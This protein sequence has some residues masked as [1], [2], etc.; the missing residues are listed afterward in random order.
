MPSA[1][2]LLGLRT[3]ATRSSTQDTLRG[4]D[5]VPNA[6]FSSL[7]RL[8]G[9]PVDSLKIDRQFLRGVPD[10]PQAAAMVSAVLRLADALGMEAVAEGVETEAQRRFLL[11]EGCR[12]AQGYH[13]GRPAPAAEVQALLRA[14]PTIAPAMV[15]QSARSTP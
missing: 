5:Q 3:R 12:F 2:R 13:L 14:C 10:D 9:L 4:R 15:S 8:R 6:D 7:S 11:R 1:I